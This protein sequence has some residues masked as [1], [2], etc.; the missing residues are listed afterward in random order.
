MAD[1][2]ITQ[3]PAATTPLAGTE[4]LP[5]V[6]SGATK[7][8]SV[9]NLTT[10]RAIA[11][12]TV[13]ATTVNATTFDT[14]VAAAALTLSG[15]SLAATGTDTNIGINITP[16]GTGSV[17]LSD[18]IFRRAMFKDTGY[19]YYDSTT[20]SALDYLNGSVQ[21]WAPTGTVTLTI[22]GWP[23]TGNLGELFI[24]GVNLGA[25]TITWP[26]IN[27]ITSTGAT[28][29][30]FALNGVTLQTTG[31]DWVLLWTRDAGTTIY[32]KVVR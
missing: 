29:T 10:G 23:P 21:R 8:V 11:A 7:Q 16:K 32:G 22:T 20:T 25:A 4:V 28:T 17:Q 12:T 27:W 1:L 15:V 5:I 2:K 9:A 19:T 30:T 6:Q 14:N 18:K 24:E 31:T 13:T 26:T 3:L